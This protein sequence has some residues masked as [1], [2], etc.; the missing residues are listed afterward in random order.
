MTKSE[1]RRKMKSVLLSLPN[2]EE[3]SRSVLELGEFVELLDQARMV[4][5]YVSMPD[6][7]DTLSVAHWLWN[8]GKKVC[9]PVFDPKMPTKAPQHR[10]YTEAIE[11]N[12]LPSGVS[13]PKESES[14]GLHQIDFVIVPGMAFTREGLRLGRGKGFYDRMLSGFV[15]KTASVCFA[16]QVLTRLPTDEHDQV[17]QRVFVI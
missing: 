12:T 5:L 10:L 4:S 11:L 13:F 15:G 16:E 2:R 1:L 7:F 6:E 17:V 9:V 3:R 8:N 14:V